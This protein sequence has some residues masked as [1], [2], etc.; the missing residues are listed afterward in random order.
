MEIFS[1]FP[2]KIR[3]KGERLESLNESGGVNVDKAVMVSTGPAVLLLE[4]VE[5]HPVPPPGL[6]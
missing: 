4:D 5:V 3:Q 1:Q 2:H 6:V